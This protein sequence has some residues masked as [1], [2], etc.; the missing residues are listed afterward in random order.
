MVARTLVSVLSLAVAA[1]TQTFIVDSASG[2]GTNFTDIP[3]AVAAVP[4]GA[5]L[6]VRPGNY[7]QFTIDGKSL[8]VL[9]EPGAA[10]ASALGPTIVN[11]LPH[12]AVV[13]RALDLASP[14]GS[15]FPVGVTCL[16]NQGVVR[17]ASLRTA[18]GLHGLSVQQCDSVFVDDCTF[19]RQATLVA[20]TVVFTNCSLNASMLVMSPALVQQGGRT[21]LVGCQVAGLTPPQQPFVSPIQLN[22]GDVR[23]LGGGVVASYALLGLPSAAI[24]GTGTVRLDPSVSVQGGPQLFAPGIT[25][26]VQAMPHVTATGGLLGGTSTAALHGPNG[27]LG[28]LAVG[29]AGP[30]IDLPSVFGD[31]LFWAQGTAVT[32]SAGVPA[33]SQP[34]TGQVAIPGNPVFV[35]LQLLYQG[36]TWDAAAGL[37]ISNPAVGVVR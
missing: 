11:L 7:S 21:Q 36:I 5:V 32:L 28:V 1:A 37:Q 12:Q 34:V 33:P 27:H 8:A 29:F 16:N 3:P 22:G 19:H 20:S 10:V 35:G 26:T 14:L 25:A 9:G 31:P 23:V 2:P 30:E 6:L 18:P 15:G 13:L 17:L 4:D 24:T